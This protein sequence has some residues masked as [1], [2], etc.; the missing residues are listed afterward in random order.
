MTE[1][2]L[3]GN[4]GRSLWIHGSYGTGKSRCAYTLKEILD[5]SE[6]EVRNYWDKYE[7]LKEKNALLEK[8]IGYK[9]HGV[10][11]AFRYASGSI[12][13]PQQLF[14]A[15]Q[16]SVQSALD[17]LP[18]SYKGENTLK[19]S[20]IAW[21]EEPTHKGFIN[22]LL[23]KPEWMA[24]FSQS[25]AD[26]IINTLK[27]SEEVSSL[28]D[29]IFKLASKE[30]ITALS[31]TSD[32]L[33]DWIKDVVTEN[34]IRFVLIWDEFSGYFRQNKDSVDELQ[35]IVA[36]CQE[37]HFYF[38][39][40]THPITSIAGTALLS[41]NKDEP[42][43]VLLQRFDRIEISLPNNIAF[44]LTGHAF[45]VIPAARG[46]W[47]I[48]TAGLLQNVQDSTMAVMKATN[49]TSENVMKK[50]LPIHPMAALVL[51]NIASAFQA[52]Q[53]SMFDFIKTPK[54]LD[55][56][57]FQWFIQNTGPMSERPFL[58]V[59]ML[60]DF[61]YDK[62][63]DYLSPDIKL[64]LDIFPQQTNLIEKEKI[65][66]KTILI[67]QAVDQRLGGSIPLLKPTDQHLRYA[68]EGDYAE[69]ENGCK[70]IAKSLV[71]KGVLILS[72]SANGEQVY[73][74]AVLAGDNAKIDQ[75]KQQVREHGTI[76]K[77]IDEGPQLASALN[78]S[79]PLRL[80]FAKDINKGDLPVVTSMNFLKTMDSLKSK[81]VSWQFYAVLA[82]SKTD[83]EAQEFRGLIRKTISI[84]EYKNIIVIDALSTPLGREEFEKY[85]DFSAMALYYTAGNNRQQ[86]ND[87]SRKAKEILERD[88]K[89]RIYDGQFIIWTHQNQEGERVIGADAVK[90][91]MQTIVL[92][93]FN[94]VSDF[95][96]GLT[97]T[98]LKLTQAKPVAKIGMGAAEVKGLISGC[99]KSVL[100][101]VWGRDNYWQDPSL[102]DEPISI[103]KRDVNAKI[104][105]AFKENG[106]ISMDS[107]YDYLQREYGYSPCNLNAFIIGFLLKEY[108]SN[109]YRS[110]DSDGQSESMTPDKLAEMIA[111]CMINKS[112]TTYIV[113]LTHE[114]KSFYNLTED[115][116]G[117]DSNTCLSPTQAGTLVQAKMRD[118]EYPVWA[119]KEV[120]NAG[121]YDIVQKYITLVQADGKSAH[122]TAIEIGKISEQR[123]GC[124]NARLL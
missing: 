1:R 117:I 3:S 12:T 47:E 123:S 4:T 52:D 88:W 25:T 14:L 119:L 54:D 40:V 121:V 51:K 84:D 95:T 66:L 39:I 83:D 114:E 28:M 55:V 94:Y 17:E 61:F 64:I 109:P 44:E 97:E 13:S 15:V 98:Q 50:M 6:E 96:R 122:D 102:K 73:S 82:L 81:D 115:A 23:Q 45:S 120:D 74:A 42:M 118:L 79:P 89:D 31:I 26:E 35:K 124:I 9:K 41:K 38:V 69:Y 105:N 36:L 76:A 107:I 58:T 34:D 7:A 10:A 116:W 22:E 62:G 92:S 63:Q 24:E 18:G 103:I 5:A 29:S 108:S 57:A 20:V 33:C 60:W 75:F 86:A 65:V 11:T 37:V 53:R 16:E 71:D 19:E 48:M 87:N 80:R 67:M 106:R 91:A 21:L 113:S 111:N 56:H 27:K 93:R 78:L 30:G 2:M 101:K 90:T 70:N 72:P 77:L 99:E 112:K 85:V 104:E 59:D 32:S 46:Q 68:F 49:V 43:S 8:L 110:Q 100:G